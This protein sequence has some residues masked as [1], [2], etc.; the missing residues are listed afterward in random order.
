MEDERVFR[1]LVDE[2]R[3][4]LLDRLFERDGQT[5]GELTAAVPEMTRQGVMKHLRV[6]EE[7][8]LVVTRRDGRAKRH[9][10]N[11]VPIRGLH[12]RWISRYTEPL[13]TALG[14]LKTVMEAPMDPLGT[15]V[16]Q[17]Y[18]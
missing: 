15:H 12:D 18:I 17:V 14:R 3:R 8:E 16:Y 10:L 9:F 4:R 11:P 1:A 6:L 2:H 5:L 7:A 13:A